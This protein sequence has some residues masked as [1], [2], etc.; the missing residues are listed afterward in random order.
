[1]RDERDVLV[2]TKQFLALKSS[3]PS[4]TV[5]PAG[6]FAS[7]ITARLHAANSTMIQ[8]GGASAG[9]FQIFHG[10]PHAQNIGTQIIQQRAKSFVV[11]RG[12]RARVRT[13]GYRRPV[14]APSARCSAPC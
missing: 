9:P 7:A 4:N 12:N 10:A 2:I 1:M 5:K 6:S 14:N 8:K 3:P 11:L 13:R